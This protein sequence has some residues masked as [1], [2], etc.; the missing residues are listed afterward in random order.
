MP[1]TKEAF[2]IILPDWQKHKKSFE[3]AIESGPDWMET[4]SWTGYDLLLIQCTSTGKNNFT[5][6]ELYTL[7]SILI[8]REYWFWNYILIIR[9]YCNIYRDQ[10][11]AVVWFG[12]SPTPSHPFSRKQ[13]VSLCQYSCVRRSRWLTGWGR[14]VEAIS[15]DGLVLYKSFNTL[16]PFYRWCFWD[17][18]RSSLLGASPAVK[19]IL[20]LI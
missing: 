14:G 19:A 2:N 17:P 9:V 12:S 15:Y 11:S 8:I 1:W 13:V 4:L 5:L 7:Y 20:F 6:L 18:Q 3:T 16:S 10:T